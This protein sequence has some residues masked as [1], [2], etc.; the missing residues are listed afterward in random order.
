MDKIILNIRIDKN[1]TKFELRL[2]VAGEL[3]DM[4]EIASV[5][6]L[7]Q[8]LIEGVDKILKRNRIDPMSLSAVRTVGRIDKN[9]SSHK[10]IAAFLQAANI[11]IL[12]GK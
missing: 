12:A 1:S 2:N 7:D 3:L 6:H 5:G 4:E 11:R 8:T 9:S 10:I